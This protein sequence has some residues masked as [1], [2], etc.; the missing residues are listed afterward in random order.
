MPKITASNKNMI[1]NILEQLAIMNTDDSFSE[2][3]N[4]NISDSDSDL[5]IID[6]DHDDD[7][8][9]NENQPIVTEELNKLNEELS[10]IEKKKKDKPKKLSYTEIITELSS[11]EDKILEIESKIK[12]HD[13]ILQTLQ[14]EQTLIRKSSLRLFKQI[15][16]AHNEDLIKVRKEKKKRNV[17]EDSGILKN[18]P[19]PAILINFL[20]LP[21]H[22]ELPRTKIMSL[23]SNK[24]TALGLRDGQNIILDKQT[25]TLF[26]KEENY[27]IKFKYFQT[28]LK[29]IYDK[30]D[31]KKCEVNL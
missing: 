1:N 24:F 8:N 28:F 31:V 20:E 18:K 21:E 26:N 5:G 22:T 16:K 11:N 2:S 3:D 29:E 14:R 6:S 12:E 10:K 4:D 19:I 25:A 27:V 13:T 7:I 15:D 23:L 30:I 17:T 9:I